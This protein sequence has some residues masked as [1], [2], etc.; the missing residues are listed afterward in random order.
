[1]YSKNQVSVLNGRQYRW[2]H[3]DL[4]EEND[5]VSNIELVAVIRACGESVVGMRKWKYK[6]DSYAE[7]GSMGERSDVSTRA[8]VC[9]AT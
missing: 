8:V 2:A 6:G 4:T 3:K 5:H 7:V 1:M 9:C